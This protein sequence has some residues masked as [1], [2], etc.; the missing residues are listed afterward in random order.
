MLV[1]AFSSSTRQ[2]NF[3][4]FFG[5]FLLSI[6]LFVTDISHVFSCSQSLSFMLRIAHSSLV[7][8]VF[9]PLSLSFFSLLVVP[10]IKITLS[11]FCAVFKL[12]V[13]QCQTQY[14][15]HVTSRQKMRVP[16]WFQPMQ[17]PAKKTRVP[18]VRHSAYWLT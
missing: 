9:F 4:P 7:L 14:T 6:S 13:L 18:A 10:H 2:Y 1:L 5:L 8:T 15:G 16:L 3:V 17:L 12:L 11:L